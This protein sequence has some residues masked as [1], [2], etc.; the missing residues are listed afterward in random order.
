MDEDF[1]QEKSFD[2]YR[3]E[4]RPSSATARDRLKLFKDDEPIDLEQRALEVLEALLSQREDTVVTYENIKRHVWGAALGGAQTGD[5][6]Q[7]HIRALRVA[8]HDDKD[9]P[10]FIENVRKEG[11]KFLAHWEEKQRPVYVSVRSDTR[12]QNPN[13]EIGR[14]FDEFFGNGISTHERNGV[15]IVQAHTMDQ[16]IASPRLRR[17]IT[18]PSDRMYKGH[19]WINMWDTYGAL[20]IQDEFKKHGMTP[21]RLALIDSHVRDTSHLTAPFKISM[22]LGF[23]PETSRTLQGN[24]GGHWMHISKSQGDAVSLHNKLALTAKKK[25]RL[26]L[27]PDTE[28][29]GFQRLLPDGWDQ[30]GPDYLRAWAAMLDPEPGLDVRDYAIIFRHTRLDPRQVLFAIAGFTERSTAVAA[31]YL[32]GNWQKL[33]TKYVKGTPRER[34]RGDF[35]IVI[36]GP[37]DPHRVNEWSEIR[38]FEITPETLRDK[39]IDCEWADRLDERPPR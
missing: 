1:I 35:L 9:H 17:Q 29:K 38:E 11:Y 16:L 7:T 8:L 22:G 3:F 14:A 31:Q 27:Q 21:P 6:I 37:S 32:A 13:Q 33:W 18:R 23:T 30:N 36:E 2:G 28:N 5:N 25:G 10:K 20:A 26:L 34:S 4:I 39:G 24:T 12:A 15:I 19:N